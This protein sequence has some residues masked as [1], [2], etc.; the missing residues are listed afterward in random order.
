MKFCLQLNIWRSSLYPLYWKD[1]GIYWFYIKA[2]H[3]TLSTTHCLPSTICCINGLNMVTQNTLDGLFR[4]SAHTLVAIVSW[5]GTFLA[6]TK[7]LWEHFCPSVSPSV[8]YTFFTMFLSS[9]HHLLPMTD[10]MHAKGQVQRSKVKATEVKT[11]LNH[12]RTVTPVW[13][14]FKVIFQISRSHG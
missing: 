3:D 13:I 12:F 1:E 14:P 9:Y 11:Q 4:N 7:Q 8:C 10:V 5:V 2:A 6:V